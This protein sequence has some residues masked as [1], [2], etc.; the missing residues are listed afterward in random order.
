MV[1]NQFG[2]IDVHGDDAT[3]FLHAQLTND[4][5]SLGVGS[6]QLAGF[7]SPKGRL[8]ATLLVWRAGNAMRIL[9]SRDLVAPLT[10]RLSMFALRAKINLINTTDHLTVVGFAGNVYVA[11]LQCFEMLPE[12]ARAKIDASCGELIRMSDVNNLPRFLWVGPKATIE[13]KIA[14]LDATHH[15]R[16]VEPALWDWLDIHAGEPRVNAATSEQFVPQM[17]NFELIGG[18]SF[19][20]GCYPGQEIIARCQYRGTIKRRMVLAHATQAHAGVEV[21]HSEHSGQPCGMV[22]NSSSAPKG[23][24]DCLVQLQ[25]SALDTGSIHIGSPFGPL[26]IFPVTPRFVYDELL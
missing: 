17:I 12:K 26:L 9:V 20:K 1:L 8:L 2:V 16:K 14:T 4:I 18:I 6:A 22:V 21:F 11:L 19:R 24:V 3:S 10:K 13:A 15:M 25:L 23:G 5:Q 7:C